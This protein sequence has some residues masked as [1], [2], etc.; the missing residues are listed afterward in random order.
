MSSSD[1]VSTNGRSPVHNRIGSRGHQPRKQRSG[2][3]AHLIATLRM[4]LHSDEC[5]SPYVALYGLHDSILAGPGHNSKP[6]SRD[7]NCLM[8][9]RV[10]SQTPELTLS[11]SLGLGKQPADKA[12]SRHQNGVS[13]LHPGSRPM[14]HGNRPQILYKC[15]SLHH[16]H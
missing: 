5:R 3:L 2:S 6:L 14:I 7:C 9:T 10:H 8:M 12:H 15:P 4:P 16:V 13:D 1:N 11:G